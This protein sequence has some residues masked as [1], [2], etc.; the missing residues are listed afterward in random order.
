MVSVGNRRNKR[1]ATDKFMKKVAT[2]VKKEDGSKKKKTGALPRIRSGVEMKSK[3]VYKGELE[4]YVEARGGD[5]Q[6][7]SSWK[8]LF[9]ESPYKC[10]KGGLAVIKERTLVFYDTGKKILRSKPE[11]VRYLG[12]RK[13]PK[14]AG[15]ASEEDSTGEEQVASPSSGRISPVTKKCK[16][17][18]VSLAIWQKNM[19][20]NAEPRLKEHVREYIEE[21]ATIFRSVLDRQLIRDLLHG[22]P[23]CRWEEGTSHMAMRQ[24][25]GN[26]KWYGA[27]E[28]MGSL[29]QIK[30]ATETVL[31]PLTTR[32]KGRYDMPLP[33]VASKPIEECLR[34]LGVFDFAKYLCRKGSIRT[35]D[36]MLSRPG[37]VEQRAHTDSSWDG[38]AM[39]NPRI[40]YLTILIPLTRQ[41]ARTGGTRVWPKSHRG[42][43]NIDWAD[44]ID[45]IGPKLNVG[46]ALV[47]DGL[48]TH[49]GMANK[50]KKKDR[51]FYYAAFAS[52]HDPNTDVTG[53]SNR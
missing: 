41:D 29:I 49:C 36:I 34:E 33:Q 35:Q 18:H 32:D 24:R 38:R 8:I 42:A 3:K 30:N 31:A 1:I 51:Y 13:T 19:I 17:E 37:S 9:K 28:T 47:F 53:V 7:V 39:T 50:S 20:E 52:G 25:K 23:T 21:G 40:H 11:V 5:L 46:D 16:H 27:I 44:S 2:L 26:Q 15:N 14:L 12:I 22:T 4:E 45:M 6:K 48:L 10:T 43:E